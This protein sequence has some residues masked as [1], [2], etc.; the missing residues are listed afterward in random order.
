MLK[1]LKMKDMRYVDWDDNKIITAIKK[2]S[3]RAINNKLT[4]E[5]VD[6]VLYIVKNK[7]D[8]K[9]YTNTNEIHSFVMEALFNVNQDVYLQ[10]K[11]Y[12]DYKKRY[13]ESLK[14]TKEL[15]EKIVIDGDNENANKDAK[16]VNT[17]RDLLAGILS[18]HSTLNSTKQSLISE[19][20]MKELMETFELNP[21]W[22][23]AM[24]EGWIHIHDKGSRYLNQINCQL[25]DL[26]NLL[27]RG[28]YLNG[29]RY[30]NPST[31]QTAFAVV[32]DVTLS[33]SAQ[34]YGRR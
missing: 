9:A 22:E 32:G 14:K 2:A 5:Q 18:K 31:I 16:C 1:V 7:V 24:K 28:I 20:I 11:S 29:G 3:E 19:V 33:T 21:E 15:S 8:N 30:T 10:Y 13:A 4:N 12:R 26:G 17:H 6:E 27:K 25:F 34:E 23:K